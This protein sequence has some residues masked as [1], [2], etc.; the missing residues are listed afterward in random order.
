[1]YFRIAS[2]F[3]IAFL[4][5]KIALA[6]P[7]C[8][9][10]IQ[11]FQ[12]WDVFG[13]D[14]AARDR[15]TITDTAI[16]SGIQYFALK[17]PIATIPEA[18]GSRQLFGETGLH[19]M[20]QLLRPIGLS[21][22]RTPLRLDL[23]GIN[24]QPLAPAETAREVS[25]Q[26][27]DFAFLLYSPRILALIPWFYMNQVFFTPNSESLCRGW[28]CVSSSNSD[29]LK[30]NALSEMARGENQSWQ[31]ITEGKLPR[32][33]IMA[34][35]TTPENH[36][37]IRRLLQQFQ[38]LGI[39]ENRFISSNQYPDISPNTFRYL[40]QHLN[41]VAEDINPAANTI[42]GDSLGVFGAP[43][44]KIDSRA[45]NFFREF[46]AKQIRLP[47]VL[48]ALRKDNPT[49]DGS[50]LS[51]LEAETITELGNAMS[52]NTSFEGYRVPRLNNAVLHRFGNFSIKTGPIEWHFI[53][54]EYSGAQNKKQIAL[55]TRNNGTRN[56]HP[57]A[58]GRVIGVTSV[59]R[60]KVKNPWE[61]TPHETN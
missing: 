58:P 27:S 43:I 4:I 54:A 15:E 28:D 26:E 38:G 45:A 1:M 53:L 25:A 59:I 16:K 17:V 29:L 3:F 12:G 32:Y 57:G 61:W 6:S 37:E 50:G 2:K 56:P 7:S 48:R 20:R 44:W 18:L 52:T 35:V 5:S 39:W 13:G 14:V 10:I 46:V 30:N 21:R 60:G 22:V 34:I 23:G 11:Q 42:S 9:Q 19:P 41:E 47:K 49:F 8:R 33:E 40:P 55:I 31:L 51:Q 36:E 24:L